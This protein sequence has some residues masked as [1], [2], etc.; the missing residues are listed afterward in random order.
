[1]SLI[2]SI[3]ALALGVAIATLGGGCERDEGE[4]AKVIG[5]DPEPGPVT[6]IGVFPDDFRCE[7]VAPLPRVAEAVGV[8]VTLEPSGFKPP[9]GTPASCNYVAA[10]PPPATTDAGTAAPGTWSFD[11]DCRQLALR[12]AG[13][14]MAEY[15]SHPEAIPVRVGK[16]GIDHRDVVLLFVDDDTPCYAR[17]I[18]PSQRA[19]EALATLIAAGLDP[20]TAP[21]RVIR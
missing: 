2:P 15:A 19:R 14:L 7:T 17:V 9:F 5:D 12:D 8:T 11:V 4:P 21:T 18:G 20:S 16:S 1:M 10:A 13:R 3:S 6:G